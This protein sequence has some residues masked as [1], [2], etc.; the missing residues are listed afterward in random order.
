MK[1]LL[2]ILIS[3]LLLSS[4]VICQETLPVSGVKGET[5]YLWSWKKIFGI[6]IWRH[7]KKVWKGFGDKDTQ[8]K[9]QGQVKNRKPNGLGVLTFTDG[10]KY[11]GEWK[12]GIYNGQG[13]RT[14]PWGEYVG[15]WKD[16]KGWNGTTYDKN[17]NTEDKW[18][19]GKKIKQ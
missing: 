1:D 6:K 17:G 15:E 3:L 2:L 14:Y 18:V 12:D 13:T 11:I 9:Y 8:P 5:L 4:P 16:G 19:M 7:P 10:W